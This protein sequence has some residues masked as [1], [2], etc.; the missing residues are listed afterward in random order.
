MK[1]QPDSSTTRSNSKEVKAFSFLCVISRAR[2]SVP[3]RRAPKLLKQE[4]CRPVYPPI[5][6]KSYDIDFKRAVMEKTYG[7]FLPSCARPPGR[8]YTLFSC[9][10]SMRISREHQRRRG[11]V[12]RQR[13]WVQAPV[14]ALIASRERAPASMARRTCALV[15]WEQ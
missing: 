12:S 3:R 1:A 5:C 2:H 7:S 15:T 6:R 11:L 8:Y 9:P 14:A 13:P 4:A 10:R